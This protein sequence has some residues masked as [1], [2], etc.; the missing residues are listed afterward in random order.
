MVLEFLIIYWTSI[1]IPTVI[2]ILFFKKLELEMKL[3][4]VLIAIALVVE[5]ATY[6]LAISGH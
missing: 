4:F 2:G 5:L 3:L 6:F 1:L